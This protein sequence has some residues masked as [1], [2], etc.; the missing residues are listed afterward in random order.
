M[1][2]SLAV[3]SQTKVLSVPWVIGSETACSVPVK[4]TGMPGSQSSCQGLSETFAP[5]KCV[6]MFLKENIICISSSWKTLF[7]NFGLC[8]YI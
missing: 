1:P 7:K 8:V 2:A 6:L 5:E 3:L 4:M